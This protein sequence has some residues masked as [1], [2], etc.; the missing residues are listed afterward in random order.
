MQRNA[1]S[2]EF[3]AGY[4]IKPVNVPADIRQA[5]MMMV[6]HHYEIRQPHIVTIGGAL[7]N[8][9]KTVD[10]LLLPYVSLA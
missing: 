3:V 8:P 6:V 10:D 5:I 1:I 7:V 9:P 2:L 4:G